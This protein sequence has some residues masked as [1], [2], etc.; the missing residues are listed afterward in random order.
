MI[1][2]SA[3]P[4]SGLAI[5][6]S[7]LVKDFGDTRAVD[8]VDLAVRA[9]SVYGVLGPNGAGK[10]T[11]IKMLATLLRPDAGSARV[12]GHDVVTEAAEVRRHV[13]LT[14]QLASVDED[15][16]GRENLLLL[17]R[18]LGLGRAQAKQRAD[19]L[20]DAFGLSEAAGRL[21]KNYSGGM[22][23][24]LDISASIVVRSEEH[25]SELQSPCN[26]VCRL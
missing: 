10:T 7:G 13:S 23:R 25:T 3:D 22:R 19:E 5:E 18:L 26:V 2:M 15:L 8:G 14:G 16:T 12:L 9:G 6:A 20:L 24:R 21:V 1:G 17:G 11:T 4:I